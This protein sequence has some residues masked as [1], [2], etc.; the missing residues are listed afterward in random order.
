MIKEVPQHIRARV[1][2]SATTCERKGCSESEQLPGADFVYGVTRDQIRDAQLDV[3]IF[4]GKIV[5]WGA[6][7]AVGIRA[8]KGALSLRQGLRSAKR[9]EVGGVRNSMCASPLDSELLTLAS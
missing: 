3:A 5:V 6:E 2:Y 9:R 8:A 4:S 1:N 7:G